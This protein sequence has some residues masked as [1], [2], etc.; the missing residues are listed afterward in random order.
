MAIM[1][2]NP[3]TIPAIMLDRLHVEVYTLRVERTPPYRYVVHEVARK[4]GEDSNGN[5]VFSDKVVSFSHTDFEQKIAEWMIVNGYAT[6]VADVV[7]K[8]AAA[9]S[10]VETEYANGT[11]DPFKLMAYF[12]LALGLQ[13]EIG[14]SE[15]LGGIV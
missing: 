13:L 6:D 14:S 10:A 5:R 3:E 15:P 8:K 9:I 1:T 11:V 4:Y 2:G 7:A 12:Q